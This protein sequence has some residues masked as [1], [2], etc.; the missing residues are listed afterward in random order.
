MSTLVLVRRKNSENFTTEF[1]EPLKFTKIALQEFEMEVSWNNISEKYNNNKF[2]YQKNQ[3]VFNVVIP[4]GFYTLSRLNLRLKEIFFNND[5]L[6][7]NNNNDYINFI[8]QEEKYEKFKEYKSPIQ[9]G[10][11]EEE[12]KFS[13]KL[14]ENYKINLT[15]GNFHKVLGFE[16]KI[17]ENEEQIAK[18]TANLEYKSDDVYVHCDIIDGMQINNNLTDVIHT[19]INI[20]RPGSKIVHKFDKPVFYNV[21]L[22]KAIQRITMRITDED[23][24]LLNLKNTKVKYKF[25]II[26]KSEDYSEKIYSLL[27]NFLH[28]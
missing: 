15:E 11:I 3:E 7:V 4:D 9:F 8:S 24:T 27:Y 12:D 20:N 26:D 23:G 10:I 19:F 13:I 2:K 14:A 6:N 22:N 17:Y 28:K 5:F 16:A 1:S 25:L 21:K 18:Y